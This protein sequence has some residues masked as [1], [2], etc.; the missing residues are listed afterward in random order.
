[1]KNWF[2]A[3]DIPTSDG[4]LS[5]GKNEIWHRKPGERTR[6]KKCKN[7]Y[8]GDFCAGL[9]FMAGRWDGAGRV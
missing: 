8:L 6:E 1:M 2:P 9:D 5:D 4:N 3:E 7:S